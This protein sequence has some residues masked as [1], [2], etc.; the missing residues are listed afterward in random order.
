MRERQRVSQHCVKAEV[1]VVA[2]IADSVYRIVH[3][4]RTTPRTRSKEW[5]RSN[6]AC[7]SELF[8]E[9]APHKNV[10]DRAL[11]AEKR[12][13][14]FCACAGHKACNDVFESPQS[15]ATNAT[16]WKFNRSSATVCST[17][18]RMTDGRVFQ[19]WRREQHSIEVMPAMCSP[20]SGKTY[21]RGFS[22][23]ED[24]THDE[25]E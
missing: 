13:N 22:A 6:G 2:P 23:E 24:E 25:D 12:F 10:F 1:S 5:N 9:V 14:V 20:L 17:V 19:L 3:S 4:A 11:L 16:M 7:V 8:D 15:V 18:Y 21:A